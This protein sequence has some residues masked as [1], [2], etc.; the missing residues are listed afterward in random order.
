MIANVL[1]RVYCVAGPVLSPLQALTH[2]PLAQ[3]HQVGSVIHY[4]HFTDGETWHR[5]VNKLSHGH[6]GYKW[7]CQ[8]WKLGM[9]VPEGMLLT[10]PQL[11]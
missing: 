6:T 9:L 1:L 4:F 3:L 5:E 11:D 8:G 7:G 2:F 10:I